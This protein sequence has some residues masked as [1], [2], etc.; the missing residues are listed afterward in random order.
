M[1]NCSMHYIRSF[2]QQTGQNWEFIIHAVV[3]ILSFN[4][5]NPDNN[6][7]SVCLVAY[8]G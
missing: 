8:I 1:N 7:D 6:E 3:E 5:T 2:T 4:D